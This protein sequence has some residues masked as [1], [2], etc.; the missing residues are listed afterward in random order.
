MP[1]LDYQQTISGLINY[2]VCHASGRPTHSLWR[3]VMA[4][5]SEARK[6]KQKQNTMTSVSRPFFLDKTDSTCYYKVQRNNLRS[7]AI[8][9]ESD[10]YL[11]SIA[12]WMVKSYSCQSMSNLCTLNYF[13]RPWVYTK[14]SFASSWCKH[15]NSIY[16][17]HKYSRNIFK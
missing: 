14:T 2:V 9:M 17:H 5:P 1:L 13:S 4:S 15:S 6:L 8:Y 11:L 7:G 12:M 16:V 10:F 3:S